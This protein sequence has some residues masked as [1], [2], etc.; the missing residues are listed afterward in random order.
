M[1]TKTYRGERTIDGLMVTVNGARLDEQFSV[2][3]FD[4][5]GF[6][7]SYVG[8]A[9]RQ[10]A[11]ALLVDHGLDAA[12]ALASVDRFVAQVIANLDNDWQLTSE[13]IDNALS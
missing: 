3:V 4:E 7:W 13:E 8:T 10:L 6:E 9:P 5:K 11:L 12:Q 2:Q 1:T